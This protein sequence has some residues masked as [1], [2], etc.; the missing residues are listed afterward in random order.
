MVNSLATRAR[1]K[2]HPGTPYE[3]DM[4]KSGWSRDDFSARVGDTLFVLQDVS[5]TGREK[6]DYPTTLWVIPVNSEGRGV[7]TYQGAQVTALGHLVAQRLTE[8]AAQ[9]ARST[10][11]QAR[12]DVGL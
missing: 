2:P 10:V 11:D 6:R 12:H 7:V 3:W 1:Q 5:H 8:I 4:T 9:N